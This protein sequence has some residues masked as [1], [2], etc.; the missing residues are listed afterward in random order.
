MRFHIVLAAFLGIAVQMISAAR[1]GWEG[2][3][4]K[5]AL[6]SVKLDNKANSNA[7]SAAINSGCFGDAN[8]MA[9]G[10]ATNANCVSQDMKDK[11]KCHDDDD[12]C[13][14]DC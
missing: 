11:K 12:K 8:S 3:K 7:N 6:Q 1:G 4:S 2:K 5:G 13:D 14:I 9:V 10:S